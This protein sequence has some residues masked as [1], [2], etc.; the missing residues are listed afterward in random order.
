ML[1]LRRDLARVYCLQARTRR[2]PCLSEPERM[3][4]RM[5]VRPAHVASRQALARILAAITPLPFLNRRPCCPLLDAPSPPL[6]VLDVTTQPFRS[7]HGFNMDSM[8]HMLYIIIFM[9][10]LDGLIWMRISYLI[11]FMHILGCLI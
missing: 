9:H 11:T 3:R 5:R 7:H 8:T 1:L 2:L 6:H 4:V 10:I